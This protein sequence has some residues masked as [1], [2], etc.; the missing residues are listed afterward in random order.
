LDIKPDEAGI[1]DL[2]GMAYCLNNKID[3]AVTHGEIAVRLS[4]KDPKIHVNLGIFYA[5]KGVNSKA[6]VEWRRALELDP[7]D[8]SAKENIKLLGE[9]RLSLEGWRLRVIAKGAS[10]EQKIYDTPIK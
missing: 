9:R 10:G 3:L 2:L 6:E 1:H 8:R 4:P 5:G 7:S